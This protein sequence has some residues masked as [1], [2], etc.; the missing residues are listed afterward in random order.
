MTKPIQSNSPI[1]V[2]PV[3]ETDDDVLR[4]ESSF[5]FSDVFE[6]GG[7][8]HRVPVFFHAQEAR[9]ICDDEGYVK[10]MQ[11]IA[12]QSD[13]I[14]Q[15]GQNFYSFNEAFQI[16]VLKGAVQII[17][18]RG[19]CEIRSLEELKKWWEQTYLLVTSDS[20]L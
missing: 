7:S 17:S 10:L 14:F 8:F 18:S 4:A 5:T 2:L 15:R 19:N 11:D 12:Q 1:L 9:E 16:L 3:L 20:I 13:C 6:G